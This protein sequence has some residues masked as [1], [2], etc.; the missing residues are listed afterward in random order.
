MRRGSAAAGKSL[1]ELNVLCKG[2]RVAA[3]IRG[4]TVRYDLEPTSRLVEGDTVVLI[5]SAE[6]LAGATG[7]FQEDGAERPA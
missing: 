4:G 5:G 6:S 2:A 7:V 3:M 1:Q